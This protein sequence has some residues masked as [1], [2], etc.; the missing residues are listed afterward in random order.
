[1][2]TS[3]YSAKEIL[4]I[5][6]AFLYCIFITGMV[7]LASVFQYLGG[8]SIRHIAPTTLAYCFVIVLSYI[9]YRRKKER[10]KTAILAWIVG[11]LTIAFAIFAKYNYAMN[12]SWKYAVQGIHIN[13]VAILSLIVLQFLYNR[14][15]YVFFYIVIT[16]HW[17]LFLYQAYLNGVE[18][19]SLGIINGV[20]YDG[21]VSLRQIYFFIIM[22][23]VGYVNYKNIPVI[24]DFDKMTT[25]QRAK[26]EDQAARQQSLNTAIRERMN[27]LFQKVDE[28][29][30]ELGTFNET[31]QNQAS[32][33]EEISAT[34][35]ELTST[36]EK[37][38]EV[39]E[40]QVQGNTDI[41]YTM[42]EFFEIKNQT[43]EKLNSSLENIEKVVTQTN[44]GN[45]IL[46]RVE[47]TIIDIKSESDRIGDTIAM[48]VDIAD[49]I[50]MLSLN[51]SIEAARAGEHGRGFAVVA[52]EIGKLASQTGESVKEIENVLKISAGKTQGGVAIIKEASNNIKEMIDQMLQSSAK[53]DDLRDNI[54]LEEK[55]L[56]GIDRQMKTNVQLSRETGTGTEEQ[57]LA[58]ETTTSAVE[59][60]SLE[61]ARMADSIN[62]I[63]GAAIKISEEARSLIEMA[64]NENITETKE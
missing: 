58:L 31:L 49:R 20:P 22:V 63:T 48:I 4:E 1:M 59:N 55:F 37:I 17:F 64:N 26:I 16:L 35:E 42:Q 6:G 15:L 9:I 2:N 40:K 24:E 39:A 43:K 41:D 44:I 7:T 36:S 12:V 8:S 32:T 19:P 61:V 47:G 18:M 54:F 11:F 45:D 27:T 10:K 23:L 53:I 62:T 57:K 21:V 52:N 29:T 38:S 56:Q 46:E 50:N 30:V 51:A 3:D 33:F 5:K 28:Q 60:M 13:A 25:A 14:A 34:I